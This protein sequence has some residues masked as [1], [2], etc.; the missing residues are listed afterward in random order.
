MKTLPILLALALLAA[1]VARA[2]TAPDPIGAALIPPDVV[3]SHQSDLGLTAAQRTAIQTEM[4]EAQTH[5]TALQ[6]Q[7][8]SAIE[9][10]AA[11][12]RQVH[13][14]EKQALAQLDRE[15]TLE[16]QIKRAQLQL[17]IRIKNDLTSAQQKKAFALKGSHG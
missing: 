17:M 9:T 13:V 15:Q 7:L 6:W 14:D 4:Q 3:M 1:G 10:L 11:T 16:R 5:F 12:L 2:Q 8:S